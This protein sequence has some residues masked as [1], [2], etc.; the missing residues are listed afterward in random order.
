[1]QAYLLDPRL[2][3]VPVG[4]WGELYLAGPGLARGY[5][6]QPGLTA[7][8]FLPS[9]FGEGARLFRTGDLARFREDGAIEFRGRTD[10]Q[11]K[12]RGVRVELGEIEAMLKQ[13]PRVRE[14]VVLSARELPT[15]VGD[16][17]LEHLLTELERESPT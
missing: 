2:A 3:P 17:E 11:V 15:T 10:H 14:A 7:E 6:R 5:Q 4:V 1:M 13:H 9:P 8:K 16:E 12:V